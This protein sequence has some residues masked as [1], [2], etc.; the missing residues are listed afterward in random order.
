M[1]DLYTFDASKEE[2]LK[3]YETVR[4]AYAAF[5]NEFKIPYLTAEAS[6]GEIGGDL[7]HEYHFPLQKGEDK[8]VS[9]DSCGYIANEELARSE[10]VFGSSQEQRFRQPNLEGEAVKSKLSLDTWMGVTQDRTTLV[11]AIFPS[12]AKIV[13]AAGES[14]RDTSINP[15]AMKRMFPSLDMSVEDP[16][17][18]ITKT[19]RLPQSF[20]EVYDKRLGIVQDGMKLEE[21]SRLRLLLQEYKDRNQHTL[22][23]AAD[24]IR[25]GAGD[26]CAICKTGTLKVQTAVELGHTFHLG[27]RYSKPLEATVA[28]NSSQK[29][30]T[31]DFNDPSLPPSTTPS[32]PRTPI[33]M[34]CHGIGV[35]RLIAAV[36]DSLSDAK[37]LNW[38]SVMAPFQAVIIPTSSQEAEAS[39]VYDMLTSRHTVNNQPIDA[40]I[41]DRKRDFGW[42]IRDADLIGYPVI[43]VVGKDWKR[44]GKVEVQC[45]R[46]EVKET[47]KA[48]ELRGFVER[49]LEKL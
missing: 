7:S 24:I 21:D 29:A 45:R 1:K 44:E 19:H 11:T 13:T 2:A 42:K 20:V 49:L 5:F 15:Y 34:G 4:G 6:S 48:D 23:P 10:T 3:T 40:I 30:P 32:A 18:E 22:V 46:L 36:A 26:T 9:C 41:D 35:S 25:I 39:N 28:T 27:T 43:M 8:I 31:I 37:G 17:N 12:K 14:S 47:V 16:W 33:Q 38:P